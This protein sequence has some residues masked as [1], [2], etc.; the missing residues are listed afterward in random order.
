M[1]EIDT[2]E[3]KFYLARVIDLFSRRLLGYAMGERHGAELVV[4]SLSLTC[5]QCG[6]VSCR[7]CGGRVGCMPRRSRGLC[8][9]RDGW[10]GD[11]SSSLAVRPGPGRDGFSAPVGE[12]GGCRTTC[13]R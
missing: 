6:G 7:R 10:P 3:G 9:R 8:P 1:T 4:A 11:G 2:S 5:I 12:P 13:A